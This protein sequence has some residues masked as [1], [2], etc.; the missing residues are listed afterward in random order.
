MMVEKRSG[1]SFGDFLRQRIFTPLGMTG[2]IAYEKGR[3]EV[4]H[5][6]YGHARTWA[7]WSERI[8]VRLRLLWATAA[9]Y[10]SLDDLEKWDGACDPYTC[11]PQK[12]WNRH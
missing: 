6:A 4:S 1:I 2:T 5:R 11:S 8:R 7:G 9:V 12:K 10:T 3:N